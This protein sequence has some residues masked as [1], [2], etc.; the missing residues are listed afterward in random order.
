MYRSMNKRYLLD[1]NILSELCR[2]KPD[3]AVVEFVGQLDIFWLSV[4]TLHELHF[5][6]ELLPVGE[7]RN[8]LSSAVT[9]LTENYSAQLI[10]I[11]KEVAKVAAEYRSVARL[12]GKALHLA[13]SLIAASCST[14]EGLVV[15][16]RN[17]RDFDIC[18]IESLNPF[19]QQE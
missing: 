19:S 12:G 17:I 8:R 5:G 4:I 7:R 10:A 13:D 15:V 9:D 1:T 3:E 16:T 14:R 11:D 18:P 6:I 2:E